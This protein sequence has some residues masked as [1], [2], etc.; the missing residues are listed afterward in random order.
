MCYY[1]KVDTKQ[2]RNFTRMAPYAIDYRLQSPANSLCG[3]TQLF[4]YRGGGRH[5]FGNKLKNLVIFFSIVV[6]IGFIEQPLQ[7]FI[8]SP[9]VFM[10]NFSQFENV[11]QKRSYT[12]ITPCRKVRFRYR[13]DTFNGEI[14]CLENMK[15]F[16]E[17]GDLS[18]RP[19]CSRPRPQR[20]KFASEDR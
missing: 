16:K 11:T 18:V 4:L 5:K 20:S 8:T 19:R 13:K 9:F 6:P 7:Y 14:G 15:R 17:R 2:N 3:G 12:R 10:E 1:I